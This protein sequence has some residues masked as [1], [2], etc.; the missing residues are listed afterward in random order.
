MAAILKFD[1]L[2]S[3]LPFVTKR[4]VWEKKEENKPPLKL[5]YNGGLFSSFFF[6]DSPFGHE[7]HPDFKGPNF[8]MAT[9]S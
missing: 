3:G 7:W 8:K 6:S 1:P 5:K 4:W 2:K 9:I